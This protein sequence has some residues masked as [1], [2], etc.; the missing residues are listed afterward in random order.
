MRFIDYRDKVFILSR[1]DADAFACVFALSRAGF[2]LCSRSTGDVAT[3]NLA[4]GHPFL[5][6]VGALADLAYFRVAMD[7]FERPAFSLIFL[8]AA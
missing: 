6:F 4:C 7:R 2:A 5:N 1:D 3:E 8:P